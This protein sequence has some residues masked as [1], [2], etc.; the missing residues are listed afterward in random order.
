MLKKSRRIYSKAAFESGRVKGIAQDGNR[1]WI[2]V[3]ATICADGT[4]IPP[5]IIYPSVSGAIQ[6]TWSKG[7]RPEEQESFF[8]ASPR[9]WTN[10]ELGL[11]WLE[12]VFD[13][14]TRTKAS[15]A[16]RLLIVNGHG[17]HINMPFL[18][19]CISNKIILGNYP[20]HST[21]RLQPL[22]VSL[23]SLLATYYS[24]N[25][26]DFLSRSQGISNIA[27]RNF[28]E[29]FWTAYQMAFTEKNIL[30][31]FKEGISLYNPTEVLQGL[32]KLERQPV[33]QIGGRPSS[34]ELAISV[35]SEKDW[36][37]IEETRDRYF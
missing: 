8:T 36:K 16:W 20:P 28:F 7:Y 15:R 2:T 4:A 17:S 33:S 35:L 6:D 22:D 11:R 21:H 32:A 10:D 34:S 30:G 9:G 31:S 12:T 14:S 27:K 23:F 5:G 26:D 19:Y 29:P 24:Q 18:E 13:R 37:R 3:Q 25:L 1:E